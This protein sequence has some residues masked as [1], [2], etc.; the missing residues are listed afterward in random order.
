MNAAL[1]ST[2]SPGARHHCNRGPFRQNERAM[3]HIAA[4]RA[5]AGALA[6]VLS[7]VSGGSAEP[8]ASAPPLK[9]L[10][11]TGGGYHD[12]QLQSVYLTTNLSR[13]V[14][15]TFEVRSSLEVLN[16]PKFAEPYDAVFYNVCEDTA[17]DQVLDNAMQAAHNGKPTVLMHCSIHA[18]RY[19]PKIKEWETFCGLR[20]K[21]HDRYEPFAIDKLELGSPIIKFLPPEWKTPGDELY[22]TISIAAESHK[23]LKAKSPA[24]GREH[25][26]CWTSQF[27]QGRVFCTTLGHD[28][29]TCGMPEFRQL[30]A[31]GLLWACGKLSPEGAPEPGY[32]AA[33]TKP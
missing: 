5:G 29:K 16:D 3:N 8:S 7:T 19:A 4:I 30:L 32:S 11:I 28:M 26:V 2:L 12:Y 23:L 25:I 27:G 1:R 10:Y 21:V 20:S 14:N 31:N 33:P 9:V 13:L 17:P 6:F 22:Q 24:D 18:F 15:A